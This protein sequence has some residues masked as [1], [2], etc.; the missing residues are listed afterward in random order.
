MASS[1]E[2]V[3]QDINGRSNPNWVSSVYTQDSGSGSGSSSGTSRSSSLSPTV[4][5]FNKL[6]QQMMDIS[7]ANNVWSAQQA[8]TQR[9]WQKQ[10]NQIAMD[11]NASEAAKSRDWQKMMSDTAHQ[12]E[13]ADLKAAGLNP[14]LSAMNGNGAAV[15]SGATASGYTS[16][17]A[18]GDTDTSVNGAIASLL[19]SFLS[20]QTQLQAMNT[21][22]ITNLA[23]ADKYNAMTKYATDVAA[24]TSRYATAMSAQTALSTAN[25]NAATSR[26]VSDNNLQGSLANAAATKISATIHAEASKYAADKGYLSSENVA[27]INADINKELKQMGINA[28]FDM[29]KYYPTSTVGAGAAILNQFA[30][31]FNLPGSLASAKDNF[32]GFSG[33]GR[34]SNFSSGS[35]G[36]GFGK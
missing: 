21:N 16:A 35:R 20:A 32:T 8:A 33:S 28:D 27:K 12:R 6:S 3:S 15:T 7:Q 2:R 23:V 29:A 25:I 11:F 31:W 17:G 4:S 10:Q 24:E 30:D 13:I 5:S 14:V 36:S 19:G 9:D 26:Y 22:A 1:A 18:K 34:G